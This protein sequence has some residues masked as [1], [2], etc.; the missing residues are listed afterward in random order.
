M[1]LTKLLPG[2]GAGLLAVSTTVAYAQAQYMQTSL[3]VSF[4]QD[5]DY[6]ILLSVSEPVAFDGDAYTAGPRES[7]MAIRRRTQAQ[8]AAAHPAM[9]DFD[10]AEETTELARAVQI[11][12]A[13]RLRGETIAA[14]EAY[15]DVLALSRKP[16][17]AY[18][19][20]EVASANGDQ[21]LAAHLSELYRAAQRAGSDL[22]TAA[23][24][25]VSDVRIAGVAT[26]ASTGG[27]LDNA[28]VRVLDPVSL[29]EFTASTD[30]NGLFVVDGV[31]RGAH[32]QIVAVAAGYLANETALYV[33][34]AHTQHAPMMGTRL[35][36]QPEDL[37]GAVN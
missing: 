10:E 4:T 28:E 13:Y 18:F 30:A 25:V 19:Y 26:D 23:T 33:D 14:A 15:Q 16:V 8:I 36:L 6:A 27:T 5:I 35:Y 12:T 31:S 2:I 29:R 3:P 22:P 7:P 9:P 24:D 37:G 32:L 20:A 21:L 11:A 17:H 34:P 1:K